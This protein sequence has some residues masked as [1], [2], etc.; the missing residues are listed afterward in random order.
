MFFFAEAEETE[1]ELF[2]DEEVEV[3]RSV[4]FESF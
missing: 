1:V 2:S 3:L 4:L